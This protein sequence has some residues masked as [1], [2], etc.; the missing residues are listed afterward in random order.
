[1]T[2]G[3]SVF[4]KTSFFNNV[5]ITASLGSVVQVSWYILQFFSHTDYQDDSCENYEKLS[6]FVTVMAKMRSDPFFPD[7]VY[8]VFLPVQSFAVPLQTFQRKRLRI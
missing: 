8:Y 4:A 6:K 2:S 7:T 3:V 5:T 1:M